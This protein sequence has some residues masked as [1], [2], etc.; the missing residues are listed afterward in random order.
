V[1]PVTARGADAMIEGMV[2]HLTLST[3]TF[4]R[5]DTREIV[6]RLLTGAA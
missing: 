6:A 2:M 3:A 1:D 4:D 5:A